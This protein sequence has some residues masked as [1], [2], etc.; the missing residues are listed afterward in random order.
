M[1]TF[2]STWVYIIGNKHVFLGINI[3]WVLR[4]V[5]KTEM[6]GQGFQYLPRD[7]AN[8]IAQNKH[9]WSLVLHKY[10]ENIAKFSLISGTILFGFFTTLSRTRISFIFSFQGQ[11]VYKAARISCCKHGGELFREKIHLETEENSQFTIAIWSSLMII[12]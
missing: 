12:L 6:G 9:F 10:N 7:L 3:H 4:E 1:P 5:L 8:V 11:T 2:W